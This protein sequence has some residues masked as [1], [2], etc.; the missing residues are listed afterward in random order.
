MSATEPQYRSKIAIFDLESRKTTV[1]FEGDGVIEAP[2]WARDGS[3][4]LVNT[5]GNLFKL[6]P[7]GGELTELRLGSGGYVCNNDH[8]LSADGQLLAYSATSDESEKSQVFRS[9]ADG[10]DIRLLTYLAPS[11]FHG[12]SP[13]GKWLAFV[14]ERGDGKYEL[15]RVQSE[16]GQEERLTFAG[17]YD[18][19][20]EYTPD[21]NWIYFNSNRSGRWE[22]WRMPADGAGEEDKLA[23]QVTDDAP[24]DWFPHFSPNG[25]K[26]VWL[27]FP[28][29]TEG[30]NDKMPGMVLRMCDTPGKSPQPAKIEVLTEFYG[31][32]G[33]INVNSWSP[34][35]KQFAYV[36]YEPVSS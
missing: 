19:G 34:D 13:D 12:W 5:E 35:S 21:G 36:I 6:S 32:Q 15:Y 3:Y 20:C 14:A 8:D 28:A 33:T 1:I 10:T 16:G 17:G 18:D 2:N 29:G 24:E 26:M 31:G 22:L 25:E 11:Y 9:N 30:H 7:R 27:S 23:E 4:L